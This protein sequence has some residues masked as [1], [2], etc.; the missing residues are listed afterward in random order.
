MAEH[1]T[2]FKTISNEVGGALDRITGEAIE[3]IDALDLEPVNRRVRELG[4][5]RPLS[6]AFAAF[7]VGVAAAAAMRRRLT[8]AK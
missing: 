6:L 1:T 8:V 7:A 5:E 4:R 2:P 3:L